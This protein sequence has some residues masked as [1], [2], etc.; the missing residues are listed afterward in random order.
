MF[1]YYILV[2]KEWEIP[3]TADFVERPVEEIQAEWDLATSRGLVCRIRV[4]GVVPPHKRCPQCKV[5]VRQETMQCKT[6]DC[7]YQ[8]NDWLEP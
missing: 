7:G 8:V 6:V 2:M 4:G 5:R 3:A 1:E